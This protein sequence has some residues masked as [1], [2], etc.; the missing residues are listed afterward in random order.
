MLTYVAPW[1]VAEKCDLNCDPENIMAKRTALL[2]D[3]SISALGVGKRQRGGDGLFAENANGIRYLAWR[4]PSGGKYREHRIG[5]WRAERDLVG[6][7]LTVR[8]ARDQV[9]AWRGGTIRS[10]RRRSTPSPLWLAN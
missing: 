6:E 4:Y 10:S 9:Y 5:R 3:A 7:G 1:Q 2:T 8:K